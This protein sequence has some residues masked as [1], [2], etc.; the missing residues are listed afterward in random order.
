MIYLSIEKELQHLA[1]PRSDGHEAPS[2]VLS[3]VLHRGGAETRF[4]GLL[5]SRVNALYYVVD[6][7]GADRLTVGEYDYSLE[8]DL[9]EVLSC[10]ILTAGDYV[11]GVVTP[12]DMNRKIVEY[13]G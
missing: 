9:G 8:N 11:H 10:G 3:L 7:V 5:D 1:V 6:I 12:K 4:D 13:G 2:G